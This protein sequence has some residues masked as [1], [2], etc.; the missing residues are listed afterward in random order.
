MGDKVRRVVTG[1][2]VIGHAVVRAD[3][4]IALTGLPG[5]NLRSAVIWT[6]CTL[7]VDNSVDVQDDLPDDG[8]SLSGGSVVRMV[9]FGPGFA[10]AM[11]RTL[12]VDY[13]C[14]LAGELEMEMD[15]GTLVRLCQGDV[16]VQRGTSH[17]WRNPSQDTPCLVI[18]SMVEA[19]LV[20][21]GGGVLRPTR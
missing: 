17:S 18:V 8:A 6:T 19:L 2:D 1:H 4:K 16:V 21:I 11:H 13:L 9:E 14:V 5:Q 7:P 10:S 20:S 12:S 15:G 3:E